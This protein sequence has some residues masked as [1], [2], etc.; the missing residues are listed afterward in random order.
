MSDLKQQWAEADRI[1]R[2]AKR[3][4]EE[5]ISVKVKDIH[6]QADKLFGENLSALA[7]RVADL[8]RQ[9]EDERISEAVS[10]SEDIIG[11]KVFDK[12]YESKFGQGREP[13]YG[14]IEVCKHETQFAANTRW[15]RPDIGDVFVRILKADGTPS[16]KTDRYDSRDWKIVKDV[17]P[18]LG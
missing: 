14:I 15:S 10:E 8:W 9:V 18:T 12:G 2:E 5:W 3:N 11:K 17:E 4:R 6:K 1:H 16:K 13:R 7:T